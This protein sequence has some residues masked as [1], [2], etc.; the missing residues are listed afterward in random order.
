MA[1]ENSWLDRFIIGSI[2]A[3]VA[4]VILETEPTLSG[5]ASVFGV[6]NVV[7]A[8]IFT[9]EYVWRLWKARTWKYIFTPLAIIDL[10]ALLPFY[11]VFFSDSF[12]L[13]LFRLAR[14]LSLAKLGRFSKAHSR[15]LGAIWEVRY[16]LGVAFGLAFM[17]IVLAATGMYVI[18]GKAHPEAFG[19]IPRAMWWGVETLTTIGYGE[20]YPIT[21]LGRIFTA[22]YAI[23]AIGFVG[24]VSGIMVSAVL[25][26]FKA[27]LDGE[28]PTED[29]YR[30]YEIGFNRGKADTL[31]GI[32]D[33][34]ENPFEKPK[35]D[36]RICAY[37][38]WQEAAWLQS[39]KKD[40]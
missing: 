21:P 5:W 23:V 22:F 10:L 3:S 39:M 13:R 8:I 34:R 27:D 1:T 17:V 4:V 26:S 38:G 15:I 7:F 37:F 18:E 28:Y 6:L 9:A 25:E 30:Q 2:L 36:R 16:E 19:S 31:K 20:V 33:W 24:T 29:D 35:D 12:L 11:F 40:G 32:T 14:L